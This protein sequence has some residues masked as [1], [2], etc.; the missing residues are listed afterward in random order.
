MVVIATRQPGLRP[1]TIRTRLARFTPNKTAANG[2]SV[3][4]SAHT[5]CP[6]EITDEDELRA[7]EHVGCFGTAV[8]HA[9]AQ[10]GVAPLGLRVT[11]ETSAH[12]QTGE[13]SITLEVRAHIPGVDQSV[14][15]AIA[16][17]A[18]P[19]CPVWKG[20]ASEVDMRLVA[21]LDDLAQPEPAAPTPTVSRSTPDR[22]EPAAPLGTASPAAAQA[23]PEAANAA[24]QPATPNARKG[25]LPAWLNPRLAILLLVAL[26]G[27]AAVPMVWPTG[28]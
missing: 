27:F 14:L 25:P 13:R 12:P 23:S 7:A 28:A 20:L 19:A 1:E 8:T 3:S 4:W 2:W 15:E 26:G 11:A 16:R 9:L 18:E 24:A 22:G 21:I 6:E 17:R 5:E 10:A